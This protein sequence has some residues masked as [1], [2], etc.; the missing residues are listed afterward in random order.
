MGVHTSD[1]QGGLSASELGIWMER[2]E[3]ERV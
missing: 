3:Q 1:E 2:G